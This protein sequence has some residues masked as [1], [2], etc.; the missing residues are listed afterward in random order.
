M[1]RLVN[2]K[3]Y[4]SVLKGTIIWQQAEKKGKNWRKN[5]VV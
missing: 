2:E 3:N 1:V 5:A 4:E